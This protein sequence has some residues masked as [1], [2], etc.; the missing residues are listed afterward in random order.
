MNAPIDEK[1]SELFRMLYDRLRV[2]LKIDRFES[3]F[4]SSIWI[5]KYLGSSVIIELLWGPPEFQ[6][7]LFI[8]VVA[9]AKRYG[10]RNMIPIPGVRE[11]MLAN[12]PSQ[13]G[14]NLKVEFDWIQKFISEAI[15]DKEEF[16][17]IYRN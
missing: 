1:I 16:K 17:T 13:E 9:S 14:D 4:P 10:L 5:G 7:E 11:W 15:R 8:T 12:K 6:V 3:D 2:I